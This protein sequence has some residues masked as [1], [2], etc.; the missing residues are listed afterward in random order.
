MTSD[1][2]ETASSIDSGAPVEWKKYDTYHLKVDPHQNDKATEIRLCSLRRPHMRAFHVCWW[3]FFIAFFIW[4]AIAPLQTEIKKSLGLT[5]QELWTASIAGVSGTI[6]LR[7]LLGPLCDKYGGKTLMGIIL[8]MASIPTGCTGLIQSAAGL[9][10]LRF[11]IG[12]AGGTFV[13][14]Q[15]WMS[16]MFAK[17]IVGTANG[18]VAGWGN[19]GG[20]AT[21]LFMGSVLFPLFK[22][23]FDGNADKA[24]RTVCIVPAVVGFATGIMCYFLADDTPKGEISELKKH[25]TVIEAS[26]TASFRRGALNVN[27]WILAVQYGAC[28]GVELTMFNAAALY[29]HDEFGQ[30]TE[31]AAALASIFGWFLI[32]SRGTGGFM[33]DYFNRG[34]GMRGRILIHTACLIAEG[35]TILIFARMTTL[36]GSIAV[37]CFFALFVQFAE[38]TS[39]GIVPYIDP[40]AKGTISGIVGAG[41]NIGAVGFQLCFRQLT[42]QQA[43]SIMGWTVLAAGCSSVFINIK[44]QSSLL[45]G[46][47]EGNV[48]TLTVPEKE[49]KVS[50][51][52]DSDDLKEGA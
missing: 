50:D 9:A 11:F 48:Q 37:L 18:V 2:M 38:G 3:S 32:F 52:N 21:H 30:S 15:F 27:T 16:E 39:Y 14:C 23:M 49:V 42:Y 12:I 10:W 51:D 25:G 43:Y 34:M 17:E 13:M 29:F 4:F 5:K 26:A 24:W 36:G 45:R 35:A 28:F 40:T 46:S 44:G 22:N 33:S 6:F 41:G 8:C 31:R 20:G 47:E 1:K 7:F 19:L